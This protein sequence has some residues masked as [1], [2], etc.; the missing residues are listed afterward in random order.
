M[1]TGEQE[2][3]LPLEEALVRLEEAEE[4]RGEAERVLKEIFVRLGLKISE[5][6]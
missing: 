5:V 4:E 6:N 1:S 2:K 3:V